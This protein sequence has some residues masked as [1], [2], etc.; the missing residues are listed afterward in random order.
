MAKRLL[1]FALIV[2][3]CFPIRAFGQEVDP[4]LARIE[5]LKKSYLEGNTDKSLYIF[6]LTPIVWTVL[7]PS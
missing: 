7:A 1:I 2:F 5:E 4:V 3:V 6:E